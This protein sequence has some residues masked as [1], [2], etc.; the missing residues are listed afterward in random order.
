MMTEQTAQQVAADF[1]HD[2]KNANVSVGSHVTNGI[3]RF[4]VHVTWKKRKG[5]AITIAD[6]TQAY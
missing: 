3:K 5:K 1:E 2:H 4:V 6:P